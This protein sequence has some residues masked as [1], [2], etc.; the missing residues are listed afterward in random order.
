MD[1]IAIIGLGL[2]GGSLGLALKAA[3]LKDIEIVGA[4]MDR[5]TVLQAK[6][7][8]AVDGTER[9]PEVAV[10]GAGLVIVATPLLAMPEVFQ[11]IAP[12]LMEAAVVSDTGSTKDQVMK[13]AAE[14]LPPHVDFVGGHPMAGKETSGI[15]GA[16]ATL[17]KDSLYCV[18][19]APTASKGAVNL[20]LGIVQS[21][22][23]LPYFVSADEHDVLVGGISH[24]PLVLAAAL[25]A[26][27]DRNPSWDEMSKLASSGFR[28]A[29]RLASSDA[30]L[31]RGITLTNQHSLLHWLDEYMAVLREYRKLLV[32]DVDGFA[33]ALSK[34]RDSRD[35]W[36]AKLSSGERERLLSDV[37]TVSEHMMEMFLGGRLSQLMRQ[38]EKQMDDMEKK[39]RR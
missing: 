13:W 19:P 7:R 28:D 10:R 20:I 34:A 27:V 23:A 5:D 9:L 21:I 26:M 29:S 24:L 22:G 36:L 4:D 1:R 12:N 3:K 39:H 6:K 2:I 31:S 32:D 30:A 18:V 38:Q 35:L 14:Y 37:P 8:G 11:A 15:S 25:M 16:E 17:F 33:E